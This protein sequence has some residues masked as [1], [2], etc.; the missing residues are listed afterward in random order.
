MDLRMLILL[1]CLPADSYIQAYGKD[2]AL[3]MG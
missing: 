2:K 1:A 3:E